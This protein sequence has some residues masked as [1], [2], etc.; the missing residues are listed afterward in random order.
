MRSGPR[1]AVDCALNAASP[2][3]ARREAGPRVE[4]GRLPGAVGT[5]QPG[6]TARRN[7]ERA[8]VDR[9]HAAEPLG[10]VLDLEQA[11]ADGSRC[12]AG[13]GPS[14]WARRRQRWT[15]SVTE[16]TIPRGKKRITIR[17]TAE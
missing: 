6:D 16:G 8:R 4:N 1:P 7:R 17:K 5:D 3:L 14:F 2:A 11:H 10:E 15:R 9:H 12:S 13:A